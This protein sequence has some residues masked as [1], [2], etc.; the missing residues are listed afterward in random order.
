MRAGAAQK[1]PYCYVEPF[2]LAV[3]E[4]TKGLPLKLSKG[5]MLSSEPVGYGFIGLI[6]K[7]QPKLPKHFNI[8]CIGMHQMKWFTD[9]AGDIAEVCAETWIW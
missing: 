4:V 2:P 9:V 8:G 3:H 1:F 6:N 7:T 5:E